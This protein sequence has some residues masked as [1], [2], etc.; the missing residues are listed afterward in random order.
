M[1][2]RQTQVPNTAQHRL[3]FP[4]KADAAPASPRRAR[5]FVT[6]ETA[7]LYIG[8]QRAD[9]YLRERGYGWIVALRQEL[10]QVDLTLLEVNYLGGGR[11][12][13]APQLMLG[14]IVYGLLSHRTTLR[15]LEQLA[16]LDVGAWWLCGGQQPDH[17]TIGD[18]ITRHA[19]V[20]TEE[21]FSELVRGLVHRRGIAAGVVA[22]DG[23]VIESAASRFGMLRREASAP[24]DPA[25]PDG[26]G[27]A[28]PRGPWSA[29]SDPAAVVQPR[30]DGPK[31]PA[32]RPSLLV[33][34]RGLIVAQHVEPSSEPAAI[35]PL[36]AQHQQVFAAGPTRVLLDANYHTLDLL[37]GCAEQGV[38]VLCPAGRTDTALWTKR[39]AG[40]RFGKGQ[41]TYDAE[42]NAYRCPAQQWLTVRSRSRH[43]KGRRYVAY[44]TAAC[45]HCA[46]RAQCTTARTGR[47]VIRFE[48]EEIKEAMRWVL[49]QPRARRAYRRRGPIVERPFAE[50]RERQG[51]R[52]FRR[53]GLLGVRVE[54]AL[55]CIAFNLKWALRPRA[56]GLRGQFRPLRGWWRCLAYGAAVG[57]T[58][59]FHHAIPS[60]R[61][62]LAA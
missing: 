61:F 21:F 62:S 31:R 38:D 7:H 17:S 45:A 22:G 43:H 58:R 53:R 26:E 5:A 47:T 12:P 3:S 57:P 23:T 36:L 28:P 24:R 60:S 16:A 46:L 13:Y 54:F 32:Y 9:E 14:L 6:G 33:H 4:T 41:F 29:P 18:F 59:G 34:E 48:G 40:G 37:Q 39:G 20:L 11:P 52:R 2:R 44:T 19:A 56:R 51:L 55:H 8:E 50:L 30:K 15:Q 1:R 10:A 49:E 25:P 42:R 35:P 27:P